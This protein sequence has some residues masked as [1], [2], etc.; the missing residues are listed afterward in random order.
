[1]LAAG[2]A[3]TAERDLDGSRHTMLA[4]QA[5]SDLHRGRWEAAGAVAQEVAR[6]QRL[7]PTG[8]IPAL[9]VLGRLRAR[10]GGPGAQPELD[11]ALA[12]AAKVG[13]VQRVGI[14]RAARAEAAWLAGEPVRAGDEARADYDLVVQRQHPWSTGELAF[15]RWRAGDN[16]TAPAWAAEPFALQ[17][18]GE[19]QAAADA[20][21]RLGCPYEQARALADGDRPAQL[22]ALA[23]FE[24]L[25]A[26]PAAEALRQKV[27]AAGGP[28]LRGP[29]PATRRNR[30]GL[31][32]RQM[33]VLGLLAQDLSN[34]EIAAR[35]HLSA[36]TV[37]HHVAAVM[38][39][40]GVNSRSAAA[41]I[42]RA[43]GEGPMPGR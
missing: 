7:S 20:W 6:H 38:G 15:W 31:T 16:L 5:M 11:E 37:E 25:G 29:R 26:R 4:W 19:W 41:E 18:A 8:R 39:K 3:Y 43:E 9:I 35:L 42:A 36:K 32:A 33:E 22:K 14:A 27:Q 13:N 10:R 24:R 40:L 1:M 23:L 12:L 2:L 21:E 28:T 30:F 17:M 34:A